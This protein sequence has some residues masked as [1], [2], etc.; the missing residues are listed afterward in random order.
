MT[1]LADV[2]VRRL[3]EDATVLA[4]RTEKDEHPIGM[5]VPRRKIYQHPD[6]RL[7]L[8]IREY[9][10][11]N[12]TRATSER[13]LDLD[14]SRSLAAWGHL[15]ASPSFLVPLRP[16]SDDEL[17]EQGIALEPPSVREL[18]R[19]GLAKVFKYPAEELSDGVLSDVRIAGVAILTLR[20]A[21]P[22]PTT[23]AWLQSLWTSTTQGLSSALEW[24]LPLASGVS[25]DRVKHGRILVL[26]TS[27]WMDQVTTEVREQLDKAAHV[28]GFRVE[29]HNSH[30]ANAGALEVKIRQEQPRHVLVVGPKDDV[31]DRLMRV[32]AEL[33]KPEG[34]QALTF[35]LPAGADLVPAFREHL[36][37]LSGVSAALL[38]LSAPPEMPSDQPKGGTWE[39]LNR[40]FVKCMHDSGNRQYR[41]EKDSKRWWTMD[42]AKHAKAKFKEYERE[43]QLLT[44]ICDYDQW[45][46]AM[47]GK[48]K[49][50]DGREID[51]NSLHGCGSAHIKV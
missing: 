45:G 18:K 5:G 10:L 35:N 29:L 8:P 4:A 27:H 22:G 21:S 15:L 1:F 6:A 17:I 51:W 24:M 39:I 31:A 30:P 26:L 32:F 25:T 50:E 23:D 16:P 28:L 40:V 48:F 44:H 9:E 41:Q 33:E 36:A 7:K 46:K 12:L 11:A 42:T 34:N 38:P 20:A 47:T 49:G 37:T 43:G 3:V 14:S 2:S 19:L 13:I